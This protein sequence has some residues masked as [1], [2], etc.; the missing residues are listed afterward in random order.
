MSLR[1]V[2]RDPDTT[3]DPVPE[4]SPHVAHMDRLALMLMLDRYGLQL[5]ADELNRLNVEWF[6]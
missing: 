3:A 1:L 4:A 2:V 6:G 5:L